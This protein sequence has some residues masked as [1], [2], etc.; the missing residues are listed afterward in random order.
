MFLGL[1]KDPDRDWRP[2]DEAPE[3][4]R[5]RSW[6]IPWRALTRVIAWIALLVAMFASVMTVDHLAGHLI[7][8]VLLL[9]TVVAAVW[10][11][12]RWLD[13]GYWEGLREHQS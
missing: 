3:P 11:I 5:K 6:D 12:N 1:V 9:T 13:Y 2:W 10:R 8:Y 7:A 4:A